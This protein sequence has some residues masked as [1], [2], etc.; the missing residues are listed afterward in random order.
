LR[1]ELRHRTP[2]TEPASSTDHGACGDDASLVRAMARSPDIVVRYD[3]A[4]RRVWAN[5]K[6]EELTGLLPGQYLNR[7]LED[8]STLAPQWARELLECLKRTLATGQ[9]QQCEFQCPNARGEMRWLAM[10]ASP[11]CDDDDRTTGLITI[12]RDITEHKLAQAQALLREREFRTL[13]E[14]SPDYITR[15]NLRGERVYTNPAVRRLV[16]AADLPLGQS[17]RSGTVIIENEQYQRMIDEVLASGSPCSAEIRARVS[18][19]S[20]IWLDMRVCAE[21]DENGAVV[22]AF[23]IGRDIS[24]AVALRE[25]I[26]RQARSDPLTG[27]QNRKALYELGPALVD[28]ARRHGRQLG[29]MLLDVDRFKEVNDT[30]GHGVGDVLLRQLAQRIRRATRGYDTLMRLGG[31]EFALL[32][33]DVEGTHML[34]GIAAK[35]RRVFATAFNLGAGPAFV[36]ASIGIAVFPSDGENID[37]LLAHADI[38]MYQ[39]KRAGRGRYEFYRSEF[40]HQANERLALERALHTASTGE[41][42]ELHYQPKL[43]LDGSGLAG[44]EALLRWHH[45]I[46]GMVPPDRFIPIAEDTGL[47][48]PI[49]RWVIRAVADAA[50]RW[51]RGRARPLRFALNVSTHQFMHDDVVLVVHQA[52]AGTGCQP[53]WLEVEVTESLLLDDSDKVRQAIQALTAMGVTVAIDDFGT[54]YSSLTYLA[55]FE[56]A[57]LKIDRR[58]VCDIDSEPRQRELL[59][60]FI[61]MAKALRMELVAEGVETTAQAE[62][63]MAQGCALAQ[64]FLFSEPLPAQDFEREWLAADAIEDA[65]GSIGPGVEAMG[66]ITQA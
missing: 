25:E 59:K 50:A 55:R 53:Q 30:L 64:G 31:D 33:P 34:A 63:L 22:S 17:P 40:S 7:S 19:G 36:S 44:A 37:A 9:P 23:A 66:E 18:D 38:A 28:E 16:S 3:L 62:F 8:I 27:L 56:V 12:S 13:V 29:V 15:Y 43:W 11:A 52:L 20:I 39:A 47:I 48:V 41:G 51:N 46:L 35:I 42:L 32:V 14:Q 10:C 49:G 21:T 65:V 26:R 57:C 2:M 1:I 58:F 24:A 60:A 6:Y 61:A 45:P 5:P 4:L 54:G